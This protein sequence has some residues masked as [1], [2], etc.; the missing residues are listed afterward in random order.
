M[1]N[2]AENPPDFFYHSLLDFPVT[3]LENASSANWTA[4]GALTFIKRA[5]CHCSRVE[6]Y[7][8][9]G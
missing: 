7:N 2:S 3:K 4:E 8:V 5:E 6:D 9:T 1:Q